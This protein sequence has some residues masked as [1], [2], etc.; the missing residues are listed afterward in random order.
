M[1]WAFRLECRDTLK[2]GHEVWTPFSYEPSLEWARDSL[3]KTFLGHKH[4]ASTVESAR[5]WEELADEA[6]DLPIG[7]VLEYE[8]KQW[9]IMWE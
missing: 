2:L 6:M 4:D 9:R 7:K 8:S 1:S 3:R 5:K